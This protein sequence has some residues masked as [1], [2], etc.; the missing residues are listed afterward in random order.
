MIEPPENKSAVNELIMS[1]TEIKYV[2]LVKEIVTNFNKEFTRLN[3]IDVK[4]ASKYDQGQF[5]GNVARVTKKMLQELT[6]AEQLMK[7]PSK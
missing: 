7:N 5:T 1:D 2:T 4:S 3:S 6:R